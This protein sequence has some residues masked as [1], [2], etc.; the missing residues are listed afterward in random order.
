[1][2][3]HLVEDVLIVAAIAVQLAERRR[4]EGEI[5]DQDLILP[6]L[7]IRLHLRERQSQLTAVV[8]R[9][10]SYLASDPPA[11]HDRAS[12]LAPT[13]QANEALFRLK[14]RA[15]VDS[16]RRLRELLDHA[17]HVLR[18]PQLEQISQVSR[19]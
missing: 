6:D 5:G 17:L 7:S 4:L 15:C 16:I 3:L 8:A 10:E 13:Q 11:Q 14:A 9:G 1:L 12:S 2:V 19:F 18:Q